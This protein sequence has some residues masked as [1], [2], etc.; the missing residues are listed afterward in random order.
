MTFIQVL[1]T[2]IC[3]EIYIKKWLFKNNNKI[4]NIL[5]YDPSSKE[6]MNTI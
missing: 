1:T 4:V 3:L 2:K 5:F 6:N